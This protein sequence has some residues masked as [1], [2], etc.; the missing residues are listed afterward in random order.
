[1]AIPSPL[2]PPHGPPIFYRGP[3][4]SL[5]AKPAVFYFALSGL[6]SLYEDPFNQPV[7]ALESESIRV[8]SWDLPFHGIGLD[9]KEA[10]E[11]WSIEWSHNTVF[12]SSFI[13]TCLHHIDYLIQENIVDPNHLAVAG[14]SRGGLIATHLAAQDSRLKTILGFAPITQPSV[15]DHEALSHIADHPHALKHLSHQLVEKSLRFYIGNHDTRVNTEACFEFIKIVADT[16]FNRG[17]RSPTV[18]LIIYP[19]IGHKGHGTPPE[20]FQEGAKWLKTQ[21]LK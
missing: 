8:F 5:G 7:V 18:E 11:R 19:S 10:M 3:D 21:L 20:I 1:M 6:A 12:L 16:A 2:Q 9:P 14:L 17:I 4:L 15:L 13:R